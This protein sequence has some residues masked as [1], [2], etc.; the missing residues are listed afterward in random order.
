MARNLQLNSVFNFGKHKGKT[1]KQVIDEG[2][3]YIEWCVTNLDYL[4]FDSTVLKYLGASSVLVEKNN[5][6]MERLREEDD[7]RYW[8][9]CQQ[10]YED[11]LDR[12]T[13][14]ALTDGMDGDYPGG[15]IDYDEWGF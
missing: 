3:D 14:Y 15:D 7:A 2:S 12:D 8:G 11:S 1:V 13:W 9:R 10:E 4:T 5:S 6:N